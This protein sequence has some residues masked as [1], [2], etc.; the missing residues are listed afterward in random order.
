MTYGASS[1]KKNRMHLINST[2]TITIALALVAFSQ[3]RVL[4]GFA[5]RNIAP[6]ANPFCP[7]DL[8]LSCSNTSAV[9]DYCCF[10]NPGGVILQT[11]FWDYNPGLGANDT[12]TIHGLWPDNCDGSYEQYCD[13]SLEIT[14]KVKS[15]IVDDFK[16]PGLY[17]AMRKYWL[18]DDGSVES[19]WLHEFDKHGTCM[20]TIRPECYGA[21]PRRNQNVYEYF[22]ITVNLFKKLP[23]FSFLEK[24]GIVPS[25]NQT[26]T[27]SQIADALSA[28]FGGESVY[29]KCDKQNAISEIWYFHHVQ[30][31]LRNENFVQ[32]PSLSAPSCP[33]SDIH[34]YPK[35][36]SP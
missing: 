10:E 32:I 2:S 26:Y 17:K 31:S 27:K 8:P 29:F 23:T 18:S 36:H 25:L 4:Q 19:L 15:I 24:A 14:K 28:G 13:P 12:F 6:L 1:N 34:F 30:G 21:K 22:N 3:A 16:D 35:G 9:S 33:D 20:S 11:Q 7:S 5:G